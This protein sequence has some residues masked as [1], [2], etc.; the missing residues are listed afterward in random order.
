MP[1]SLPPLSKS[2]QEINSYNKDG[3]CFLST[4]T[5]YFVSQDGGIDILGK[6][7]WCS[8]VV[9]NNC[10]LL[11]VL[12]S[13]T[14]TVLWLI[15]GH[16][17]NKINLCCLFSLILLNLVVLQFPFSPPVCCCNPRQCVGE[18]QMLGAFSLRFLTS[19]GWLLYRLTSAA[20]LQRLIKIN[21]HPKL[22]FSVTFITRDTGW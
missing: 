17:Y 19:A 7:I 9:N 21:S 13:L 18:Y 14:F 1:L 10:Q 2:H 5:H 6:V 15:A 12:C 20:V 8:L 3:Q 16:V 4:G 11:M 22:V